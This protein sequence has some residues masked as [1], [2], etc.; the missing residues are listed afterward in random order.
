MTQFLDEGRAPI[1]LDTAFHAV[2]P[3]TIQGVV[4]VSGI[5]IALDPGDIE[6]GA[7][8]LKNRDTDD[9]AVINAA[10]E[11]SVNSEL[12]TA[13]VVTD[14]FANPTV[15][16]VSSFLMGYDT[17]GAN[18]NRLQAVDIAGDEFITTGDFALLTYAAL[19]GIESGSNILRKIESN[20]PADSLTIGA[21]IFH[22]NVNSFLMG[23][24]GTSFDRLRSSIANGLEVDVTRIQ[25]PVT[26]SGIIDTEFPDAVLLGD[27]LANPTTPILGAATLGLNAAS[28]LYERIRSVDV[29][30]D[31]FPSTGDPALVSYAILTGSDSPTTQRKIEA[32]IAIDALNVTSKYGLNVNSFLLGWNG[33]AWD[34][35]A[36]RGS[37]TESFTGVATGALQVI[38]NLYGYDDTFGTWERARL[39]RSTEVDGID[40]DAFNRSLIT[41]SVIRGLNAGGNY[42]RIRGTVAQGLEVDVTQIQG[43]VTV[44]GLSG[45]SNLVDTELPDALVLG[46]S[47]VNPTITAAGAYLLGFD[48]EL[49]TWGRVAAEDPGFGQIFETG[50]DGKALVTASLSYATG[51]GDRWATLG[52]VGTNADSLPTFVGTSEAGLKTGAFL[53]G[54]NGATW[55]RLR[56]SIV[57][58]LEVDVTQVQGVVA[59]T[60]SGLLSVETQGIDSDAIVALSS[61]S[62]VTS[63]F[64]MGF[65]GVTWDRLRSSIAQGLEVDVTRVQT[66]QTIL[67]AA[68]AASGIGS[69]TLVSAVGGEQIKVLSLLLRSHGPVNARFESGGGADLTGNLPLDPASDAGFVLAPPASAEM[70]HIETV[71]GEALV[72]DLDGAIEVGGYL[73][74]YTE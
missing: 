29:T 10:G 22:L 23:Y 46:D 69:N 65:N 67:R 25:G 63:A 21:G 66:G 56:S 35:V 42:D 44:S 20:A 54:Y 26:I 38:A 55:D 64:N 73:T 74:Y 70:H 4:T 57:Q 51:V 5:S 13:V 31:Y 60:V 50:N 2:D 52:A 49:G 27:A 28:L 3:L 41:Q 9:R 15:P 12:P 61:D 72:L 39:L 8:E 19:A 36:S 59:T 34:R 18:W 11:L 33:A 45:V 53:F 37:T 62:L 24:N 14:N 58:G 40:N 47:L 6:I 16:G 32:N 17:I 30:A 7:V 43:V 68:I 48:S 1:V 71:V